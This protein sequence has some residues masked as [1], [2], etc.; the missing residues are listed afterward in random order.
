MTL[1]QTK[2]SED[3]MV[4]REYGSKQLQLRFEKAADEQFRQVTVSWI[5]SKFG[6]IVEPPNNG[7]LKKIIFNSVRS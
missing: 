4:Q 3:E 6:K 2:I 5:Y 1:V 7:L